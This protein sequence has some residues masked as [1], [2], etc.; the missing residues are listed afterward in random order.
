MVDIAPLSYFQLKNTDR[1]FLI[2]FK[3]I[4]SCSFGE[5]VKNN[6]FDQKWPNIFTN[7]RLWRRRRQYQFWP[8]MTQ[9]IHQKYK[10]WDIETKWANLS[11]NHPRYLHI[12]FETITSCSSG[13][14]VKNTSLDQ[15]WPKILTKNTKFKILTQNEQIWERTTQ[16]TCI[17]NLKLFWFAV[18]EKKSKV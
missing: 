1:Y 2:K 4:L 12:K 11:E 6:S 5:E 8:K 17:S 10:N 9:N 3:I 14:E 18:L 13:E 16:G 15:K 7:K